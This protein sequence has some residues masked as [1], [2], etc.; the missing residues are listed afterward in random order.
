MTLI[1]TLPHSIRI[2]FKKRMVSALAFPL[3]DVLLC[4]FTYHLGIIYGLIH[5]K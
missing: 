4:G 5:G 2:A 3:F 1:P